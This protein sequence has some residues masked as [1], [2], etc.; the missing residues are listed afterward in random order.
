MPVYSIFRGTIGAVDHHLQAEGRL[1]L[2]ESIE[3]V[4]KRINLAKRARKPLAEVTSKR[5]LEKI[6]DTIEEL[7]AS[8][9]RRTTPAAFPR[10]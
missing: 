7:A 6:V 3:D 10:T 4:R 2:I 8:V 1:V 5:T 9:S